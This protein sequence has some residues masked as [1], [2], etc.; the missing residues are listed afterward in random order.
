MEWGLFQEH[1]EGDRNNEKDS[2]IMNRRT[3]IITGF[4]LAFS[5]TIK[6]LPQ[7]LPIIPAP[8]NTHQVSPGTYTITST[9]ALLADEGAERAAS[10]L[11]EY[12]RTF[13][14]MDLMVPGESSSA[15]GSRVIRMETDEEMDPSAQV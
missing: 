4:V 5:Q 14:Q 2:T 7:D 9:T 10:Y 15:V 3:A 13:Y 1:L 6:V 11:T 8:A 12:L